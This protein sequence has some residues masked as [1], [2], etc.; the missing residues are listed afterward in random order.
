[1]RRPGLRTGL[2]PCAHLNVVIYNSLRN[3]SAPAELTSAGNVYRVPSVCLHA[4]YHA[5]FPPLGLEDGALLNV[6]LKVRG[7]RHRLVARRHRSKVPDPFQFRPH[8]GAATPDFLEIVGSFE[9]DLLCPNAARHHA[10]RKPGSFL[11][12]PLVRYLP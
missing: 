3:T 7:Y 6:K 8:R 9:R 11:T 10:D 12:D 1:M 2:Y 4:L 5:D